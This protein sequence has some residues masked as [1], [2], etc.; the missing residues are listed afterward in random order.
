MLEH[1]NVASDLKTVQLDTCGGKNKN[2]NKE[3]TRLQ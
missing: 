1:K 2:K 3:S